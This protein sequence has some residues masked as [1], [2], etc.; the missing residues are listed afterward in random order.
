ME[1]ESMESI[2]NSTRSRPSGPD[3]LAVSLSNETLFS[4]FV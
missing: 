1:T 2:C 4:P 3:S